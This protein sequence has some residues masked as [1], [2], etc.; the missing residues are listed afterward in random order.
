[1]CQE[2]LDIHSESLTI[3][4]YL[5]MYREAK[6]S[7][8][9]CFFRRIHKI[10]SNHYNCEET[11]CS[12]IQGWDSSDFKKK[13]SISSLHQYAWKQTIQSVVMDGKLKI[14]EEIQ[15][16]LNYAAYKKMART[17][18]RSVATIIIFTQ[19]DTPLQPNEPVC[20]KTASSVNSILDGVEVFPE[21]YRSSSVCHFID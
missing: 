5:A 2:C 3:R 8:E 9:L 7:S 16:I 10:V 13:F 20:I 15:N 1:M 18:R 4:R 17:T 12:L 11:F 21:I 14:I 19:I 6:G